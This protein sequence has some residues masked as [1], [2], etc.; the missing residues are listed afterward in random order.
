MLG[1]NKIFHV[2]MQ[3]CSEY[4]LEADLNASMSFSHSGSNIGPRISTSLFFE[5]LG[6]QI[7]CP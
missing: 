1:F 3:A 6:G 5:I 4:R 7:N 2:I